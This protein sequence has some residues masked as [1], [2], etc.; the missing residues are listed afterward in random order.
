MIF[1]Y[2]KFE[3]NC[4]ILCIH[5]YKTLIWT[6]DHKSAK[7]SKKIDTTSNKFLFLFFVSTLI[8]E[9]E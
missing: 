5:L 6:I 2:K 7:D 9:T 3:I 1:L 8:V 4:I